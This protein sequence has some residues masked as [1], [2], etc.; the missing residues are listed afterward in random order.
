MAE[1]RQQH[2]YER[3]IARRKAYVTRCRQEVENRVRDMEEQQR[4]EEEARKKVGGRQGRSVVPFWIG[5]ALDGVV[6]VILFVAPPK[7]RFLGWKTALQWVYASEAVMLHHN[8]A[9]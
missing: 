7:A 6:C 1:M 2:K 3:E 9:C 8:Y 5:A 4:R